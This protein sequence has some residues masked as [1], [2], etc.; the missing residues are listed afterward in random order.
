MRY[1]IGA[2]DYLCL[3]A[4]RFLSASNYTFD[5]RSY[6]AIV[7]SI[8]D[9]PPRGDFL[10][11]MHPHT[12]SSLL[13]RDLVWRCCAIEA[14]GTASG[15]KAGQVWPVYPPGSRPDGR[16]C[17][18]YP[19][20]P[21]MRGYPGSNLKVATSTTRRRCGVDACLTDVS[22]VTLKEDCGYRSA[23]CVDWNC[24]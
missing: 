13:L 2:W 4:G 23:T 11:S 8:R 17:C 3:P 5:T 22:V 6:V 18:I 1:I 9:V 7:S 14:P 10:Q 19:T 20:S 21:M 15:I 24:S 16:H 12:D